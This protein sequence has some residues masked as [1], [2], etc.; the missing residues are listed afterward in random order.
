MA[1]FGVS[2]LDSSLE[3]D[4]TVTTGT[5]AVI[6]HSNYDDDT[7]AGHYQANFSNYKK[8][9]FTDA[10]GTTYLY[11]TLGDGDALITVPSLETLPIT[12][13]YTSDGDGVYTLALSAVPTWDSGVAYLLSAGHHVYYGGLLYKALQNSTNKQP[14]TETTYWE[15][16]LDAALPAKYRLEQKFA[17]Y[18][19]MIVC[20]ERSTYEAV[21]AI[22]CSTCST[23]ICGDARF[24]K[25]IKLMIELY[26][27][28]VLI[29]NSEW[30]RVTAVI[31]SGS[32]MC[33]CV[34][35]GNTNCNCS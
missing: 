24:Q 9:L 35:T 34:A 30:D 13:N 8:L 2:I 17:V 15:A 32:V 25:A 20:F 28:Q 10:N 27:L 26:S 23:N 1:D 11:S 31:N 19:A 6:D 12:T 22:F 33:G 14:D 3:I 21:D 29:N 7:E 16:V 4:I 5:V 18:C